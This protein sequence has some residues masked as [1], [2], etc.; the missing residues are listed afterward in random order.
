MAVYVTGTLL[1]VYLAL[2]AQF[3]ITIRGRQSGK[4]VQKALAVLSL[5]PL[6]LISGLRYDV[7]TDFLSYEM[8]ITHPGWFEH[9]SPL[10][11]WYVETTGKLFGNT[12][13]FF[14]ISAF[15][16]CGMFFCAAYSESL[17]PA[18]TILF[19]VI[20]ED[21]F[22]SMNVIGQF[23]ACG[24]V[25]ISL[26]NLRR[27]KY[28]WTAL[29]WIAAVAF[30]NSALIVPIFM[31]IYQ[32][33]SFNKKNIA[34]A[35]FCVA[36]MLAGSGVL[37]LLIKMYT[38][39]GRYFTSDYADTQ[40][41]VAYL[42]GMI[43]LMVFIAAYILCGEERIAADNRLRMFAYACFM[44]FALILM[45]FRITGNAYR[46]TYYFNG[47]I[48]IYFPDFFAAIDDENN[49]RIVIVAVIALF[50]VWTTLL[51]THNNQ[52]VLPYR[53]VFS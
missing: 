45:S 49:R 16:T 31:F 18:F 9:F 38:N 35:L 37:I 13:C 42:M 25:W 33:V 28:L 21:Y 3:P 6:A 44:N 15:F 29:F 7:G 39:Y 11:T 46:L 36:V 1:S 24:F 27:E 26:I 52:N 10:L 4:D 40:L 17:L 34:I 12:Q 14:F 20:S 47:I 8:S 30:H 48:G 19:F 5:L 32:F 22:V 50:T 51:I 43:Y 53:T 41:S 2:R 23:I